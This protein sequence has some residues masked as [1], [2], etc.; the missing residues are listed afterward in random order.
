MFRR[1]CHQNETHYSCPAGAISLKAKCRHNFWTEHFYR[2]H[3]FDFLSHVSLR[4]LEPLV[5]CTIARFARIRVTDTQTD[6]QDNRYNPHCACTPRVNEAASTGLL[7]EWGIFLSIILSWICSN[8]CRSFF[9]Y[10]K[11]HLKQN[12][13]H[14]S[15]T[16]DTNEIVW[17]LVI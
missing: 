4:L 2:K 7:T 8:Y 3:L 9:I 11:P 17:V 6:T 10:S 12:S 13:S 15:T 16:C 14:L 5:G 1:L